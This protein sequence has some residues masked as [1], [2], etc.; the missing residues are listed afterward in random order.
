MQIRTER[1]NLS[2]LPDY[3]SK[4][5]TTPPRRSHLVVR[6]SVGFSLRAFDFAEDL[7]RVLGPGERARVVVPRVDERSDRRGE[8]LDG[9]E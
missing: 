5:L 8:L 1:A 7:V 9:G 4:A 3:G 6:K 2:E